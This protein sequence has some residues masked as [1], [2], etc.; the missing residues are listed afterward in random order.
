MEAAPGCSVKWGIEEEATHRVRGSSIGSVIQIGDR[1]FL[2]LTQK[3]VVRFEPS[4]IIDYYAY[5]LTS[6][7]AVCE[8]KIVVGVTAVNSEFMVF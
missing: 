4:R 5:Q 3:E 7:V 8:H 1:E 2:G 6:F